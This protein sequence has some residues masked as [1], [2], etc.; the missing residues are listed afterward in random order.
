MN[1]VKKLDGN[2]TYD[3]LMKEKQ[4]NNIFVIN[5]RYKYLENDNQCNHN[6]Q[7]T[8]YGPKNENNYINGIIGSFYKET[9]AYDSDI[10]S[11]NN[12][13][14][15]NYFHDHNDDE[16]EQCLIY[17]SN[18]FDTKFKDSGSFHKIIIDSIDIYTI[19][20]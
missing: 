5:F 10:E 20:E 4:D 11:I 14:S 16:G 9:Y 12:T 7:F 2:T 6:A 17:F 8:Y 15:F 1:F 3:D 19:L 13:I 18:A